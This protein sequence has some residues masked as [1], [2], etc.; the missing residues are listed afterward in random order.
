MCAVLCTALLTSTYLEHHEHSAFTCGAGEGM[1]LKHPLYSRCCIAVYQYVFRAS[2]STF[3]GKHV[4]NSIAG[5][6]N[7]YILLLILPRYAD[8]YIAATIYSIMNTAVSTAS[9]WYIVIS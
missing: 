4:V 5:N 1:P 8:Y 3:R 9:L 6:M 2:L 7:T